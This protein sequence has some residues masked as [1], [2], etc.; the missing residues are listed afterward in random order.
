MRVPLSWLREYV[1]VPAEASADDVLAS[2]VSVGFEEEDV[3]SFE[4]TGPIVV[5][6]VVEFVEEPQSNGKTIRWCQVD[7]GP[8]NGGVRGIVCGAGNF[9]AGDKV[10]VTLPGAVLP[11]PFPIAARKTY[12]HVS[13][14]MIAS[15]KELGLG[16]EHSGI[17]RLV[18]LGLDPEVGI[19]AI[20]L[21]G[22]DDVAV[23]INVTPDRGYAL[24]LRGVAREYSHA[25]G[26]AFR[27]PG[28]RAFEELEQPTGGFAVAVVDDAPIRGRVGAS[29]FVVR[30]VRDVDPTRPTPAWM[31]ARLT[32]AGIRSLGILIDITNY[33]M[34]EL[35]NPIHGYD[36]DTLAGGITVRRAAP[37]EKLTTLDGKER[38][39]HVEDLLIT[40]ES[41][42]IGLAGVMGG[43]TT[44]MTPSTRNVLIEAAIFDTVTIARTARRHKLPSEASRRF[45]R[46]V[47]PL[48]PFVAARR[49]ADLMVELAGGTLDTATGGA[50]FTE[51]FLEAIELPKAF[52]PG[53]I[54]VDYTDAEIVAALEKIGCEVEAAGAS[55]TVIP[56][57][58]RPDLTDKWTLAEEVARIDGYARIPSEL[59]VPP[60]GSGFTPAQ[61]GRRRVA[62]ALAAA[63][64]VETPSF[65]FTTDE[66][67]DLHGSATGAHLPSI[68]LA[69]PLDGQAPFLR[70]S[71]IPGL[72]QVAHRNASRGLTDLALFETG[73]VF[74]PEPGVTYGTD[75]VPAAAVRPDAATLA[76]LDAAIPPQPR[77]VA[78]LLTGHRVAKQPGVAA[79]AFDL[80]DALDAVRTIGSAAGVEITVTQSQRAALHPGRTGVLSAYGT[81]VGYVGELLPAVAAASDLPGR[82]VVAELDLDRVL[83]LAGERVVAAS[84]SGYPAATQDVS[85]V[86]P[87]DVAAAEVGAALAEGAGALLEALHLVDDYRGQG[88]PEGTK[89]LTFALRFRSADRTLTA[90]EATDAKLQ[91]VAVAAERFG[92]KI[93]E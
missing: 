32:L 80:A 39:L 29:E 40:D 58:W 18:E 28:A 16:D 23:D 31:V 26:A 52:V 21:L 11:G 66:Q 57:S 42:P 14:G 83:A 5:G 43:G 61:Q 55:W 22:L 70:R 79:E 75:T 77:H 50:L 2:L 53:L 62:N 86:V 8:E 91:G 51:V 64:L 72:L 85:V 73:T 4:L 35:G 37:G 41:G 78:V 84:L 90:A 3:F 44:E 36:L 92:A 25:T 71:L 30:I 24:S 74:L 27:D 76:A 60:S 20:A 7:V 48:I 38:A 56:P 81:E 59:P 9:F 15:A 49:V 82:V 46:G 12:G 10:V 54:G 68:K 19:D 67:N 88:L 45:E 87:S 33:V 65:G 47:D 34:L 89:S 17:L 6:Q 1:E 93:R 63:G 13:D 69:N